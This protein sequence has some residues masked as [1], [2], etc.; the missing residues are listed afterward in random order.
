MASYFLGNQNQPLWS[1]N[2]E[3]GALDSYYCYSTWRY[4]RMANDAE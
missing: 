3:K 2:S 4:A 1:L